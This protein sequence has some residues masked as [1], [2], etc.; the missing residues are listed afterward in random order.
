MFTRH[1]SQNRRSLGRLERLSLGCILAQFPAGSERSR[2]GGGV[3]E[4]SGWPS[5]SLRYAQAE[6]QWSWFHTN[7]NRSKEMKEGVRHYM[8]ERYARR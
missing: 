8:K 6:R 1:Y 3:E 4:E 2:V 7:A 5:T